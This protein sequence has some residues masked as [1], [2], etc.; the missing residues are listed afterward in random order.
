M[1]YRQ[2]ELRVNRII[3]DTVA[4]GP[5]HRTCIWVQGC[6]RRCKGCF[7]QDMWDFDSGTSVKVDEILQHI[8]KENAIEGITVLGGEPL[9]QSEPL[10][11]LIS[12]AKSEG[13]SV[14]LFTGNIYEDIV[15]KDNPYIKNI[16]ENTDVLIDGEYIEAKRVTNM[17]LIGS[18]NQRY[19]FL[20]NRYTMN[21]FLTTKIEIRIDKNGVAKYNGMADLEKIRKRFKEQR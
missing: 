11:A 2:E 13:K 17:G 6:G 16:L 20:T 10:S 9:D 8:K 21:D 1:I 12:K 18:S 4:E 3:Y 14:V 7:A 15:N 19:I 5:G